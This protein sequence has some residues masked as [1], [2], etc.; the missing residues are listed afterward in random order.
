MGAWGHSPWGLSGWGIAG[1]GE[2]L[3]LV[4]AQPVRENVVRLTF[5]LPVY[6]SRILDPFDASN[7]RRYV[8]TPVAGSRGDDGRPP[9]PVFPAVP[10]VAAEADAGGRA[11]DLT[12]D[13]PFSPYPAQY[14]VAVNGLRASNGAFLAIGHTSLQFDGLAQGAPVPTRETLASRGD[15]ANPQSRLGLGDNVPLGAKVV[16]GAY[17]VDG[18]GD[19]AVDRG[20]VSYRKRIVRRLSSRL[21][22]FAHLGRYG[23]GAVDKVKRL[24]RGGEAETMAAEAESQ[25]REE[26]E[27]AECRVTVERSTT[28][29]SVVVLRVRARTRSGEAVD[30]GI[31]FPSGG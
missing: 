27:T 15:F 7:R 6:F 20:L 17:P 28:N 12:V 10:N 21:G 3:Q 16:L 30:M 23:L 19:Y 22:G 1:P 2:G 13:R 5:N 18:S 8:I 14:V 29:P 9:R 4:N 24:D 26:P 31:P 11:I 25:I